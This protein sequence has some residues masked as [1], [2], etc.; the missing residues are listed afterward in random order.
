MA[1]RGANIDQFLETV[2][3][4]VDAFG[5]CE[6][7]QEFSLNCE[8]FDSVVVHFVLSGEGV[9][10][11]RHGRFPLTEG[12]VAIIPKG[13]SKT[14]SGAGPVKHFT[15][16]NPDCSYSEELVRFCPAPGQADLVLGCAKLSSRVAGELPLFDQAKRPIFEHSQDPLL[17]SLFSTM[18]E[19]LRN[20]RL[21]TAAFVSALMKQVLVVMLRSHPDNVSSILLMSGKRFAGLVANILDRPEDNYHVESM[22]AQAGM[23]RSCFIQQFTAAYDCSP[24]AF[25]QTARLAAAARILKTSNL[26]IK[27]VAALVGYASRSQFS[28]AFQAKFGCDPSA[29]RRSL[30]AVPNKTEGA[31]SNAQRQMAS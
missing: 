21:G 15:N 30:A 31:P 13:L 20:P 4:R 10:E 17:K 29:F 16:A 3:I 27:T 25:V 8:P 6:I 24:M 22:A 9:L 23:S 14:L 18:F 28:R 26:P 2:D 1:D 7:G 5:I 11:C 19:E 12:T